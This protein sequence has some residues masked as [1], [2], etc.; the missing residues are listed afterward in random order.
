MTIRAW[1]PTIVATAALSAGAIWLAQPSA[2]EITIAS[3]GSI[4]PREVHVRVHAWGLRPNVIRVAP[5]QRVRF[6]VSTDDI[7]HGFAINELG[8]NLQLRP[9]QE[10]RSPVV[11]VRMPEGRYAIHCSTFCGLGHASMKGA[12]VVGS[13]GRA[14]ARAEP[15]IASAI[16]IALVA[17][18]ARRFGAAH[19]QSSSSPRS[20][21]RRRDLE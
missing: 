20:P 14:R 15:W 3:D 17:A 11:D 5:G 4:E 12:L 10:T 9:G 18:A 7:K 19:R 16:A 8:L 21:S 13:P 1:L 2:R 6:V